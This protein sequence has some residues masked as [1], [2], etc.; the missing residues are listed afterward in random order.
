[1]WRRFLLSN[2]YN[3][4]NTWSTT[5]EN[6]YCS[7][8]VLY[9]VHW[10]PRDSAENI[11]RQRNQFRRRRPLAARAER[12]ISSSV[13]GSEEIRRRR[14]IQLHLYTTQ[15]AALRRIMGGRG[16]I[17]QTPGSLR[18]SRSG[19]HSQLASTRTVEPGPQRWRSSNASTPADR[20]PSTSTATSTSASGH[21]SLLREMATCLLSQATVLAA[22][23][24]NVSQERNKWLHPERNLQAG[25]LVLVHEDN[26]PPQQ[27]VLGRVAATVEGL[28]GKVRVADVATKAGTIKRPIHKLAL[29]PI[30]V[31][32]S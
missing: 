16:E 18:T 20:L 15:G 26:T 11:Q 2:I 10:S 25:D 12:G 31:E 7:F 4:K 17:R 9:F 27:W 6:L 19:S 14:R 29:L 8:C 32:G 30:N 21:N 13:N 5:R 28:D 24:Q 1:M 22:V 23:V 3:I